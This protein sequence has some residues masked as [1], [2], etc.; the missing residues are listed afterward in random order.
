M[1]AIQA[2]SI[3][4][5]LVGRD[6]LAAAKTGSGKTLAFLIPVRALWLSLSLPTDYTR[7]TPDTTTTK[8]LEMLFRA[9]WTPADGL[10][11][12]VIS[13]TRE[14]ALQIFDV[15]RKIG[16]YH[17]FSAGLVIGGKDVAEERTRISKMNILVVWHTHIPGPYV[18]VCVCA[19]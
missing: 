5:A 9:Q 15:L 7:L 10:G 17:V 19:W 13:P 6:V 12:L 1:T 18:C 14:L 8:I 11:A 4:H 3:P 16:K 2:A